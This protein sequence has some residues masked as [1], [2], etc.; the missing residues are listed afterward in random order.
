M[1][2]NGAASNEE[3]GCGF[4]GE[5]THPRSPLL[6]VESKTSASAERHILHTFILGE[7]SVIISPDQ[8]QK[9]GT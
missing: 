6:Y 5:R 1:G 8:T 4:H 9:A 3:G 7:L 2:E